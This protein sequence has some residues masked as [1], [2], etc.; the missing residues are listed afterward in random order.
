M[1]ISTGLFILLVLDIF[2]LAML[3]VFYLRKRH[4]P[5]FEYLIWGLLA[6]LIPILGPFLVIVSKPGKS[7]YKLQ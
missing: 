6:L 5:W 3:A 1:S 2:S 4:M 7:R